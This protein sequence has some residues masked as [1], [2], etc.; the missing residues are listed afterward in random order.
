MK[1][2]PGDR[3][4]MA[5]A[6]PSARRIQRLLAERPAIALAIFLLLLVVIASILIPGYLSLAQVANI[7]RL[8]SV[9]G[10][11]AAGQTVLIITGGID[12]SLVWIAVAA[13]YAVS[14]VSA[15]SSV[16]VGIIAAL[17]L[18]AAIG[19]VNGIGVGVFGASPLIVTLGMAG[20]LQGAVVVF[21]KAHLANAASVPGSILQLANDSIV[22]FVPYSAFVWVAVAALVILMLQRTG[23]GR[24]IYAVGD[25]RAACRLAGIPVAGTLVAVYA[26][27]GLISAIGGIVLVGLSRY[28]N[29]D[30]GTPFL[31]PS[32]AAVVVGGTSI[33]GGSGGYG[34]TMLGVL[35]LTVLDG[36][37]T[38]LNI[39]QGQAPQAA[40]FIL[41]GLIVLALA[42]AYLRAAQQ[43]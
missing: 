25:N 1:T 29:A 36:L 26:L 28:A 30:M 35:L 31:L 5:V 16:P 11:L 23:F 39:G 4:S 42:W 37:L 33:A 24:L 22:G 38:L 6:P 8:G 27:A 43:A 32:I 20:I 14:Y 41:Y 40:R 15:D 17:A 7:L 3:R 10:L 18:G 13:G 9:M 2:V 21:D 19:T 34:G 12:L